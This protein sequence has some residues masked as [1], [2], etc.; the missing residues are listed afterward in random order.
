MATID[1][2]CSHFLKTGLDS[3]LLLILLQEEKWHR[4]RQMQILGKKI[5]Y[6]NYFIYLLIHSFKCINTVLLMALLIS[7]SIFPLKDLAKPHTLH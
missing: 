3:F 4:S 7:D 2:S 1:G 6:F 5:L